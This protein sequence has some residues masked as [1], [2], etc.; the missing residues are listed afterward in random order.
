MKFSLSYVFHRFFTKLY[1]KTSPDFFNVFPEFKQIKNCICNSEIGLHTKLYPSYQI[2]NSKIGNFTYISQNSKISFAKI[3]N[4]CS[5]GPNFLCGWGIHPSKSVSTHPMF[6]STRKQNGITL[7]KTDKIEERKPIEIGH[8][9]FIGANVLI[10]DGVKIGTG[11]IIGAGAV[12]VKDIP[13]YAIA[14]GVPAKIIK[15]RFDE[16][17]IRKLLDSQWFL[18]TDLKKLQIVE[19]YLFDVNSFLAEWEKINK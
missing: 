3:G 5:I 6:Y 16:E 11:A 15:Y 1:K 10:L 18:E 14:V 17:T 4:F 8:D 19:K 2:K 7:S 9:V 13:D 12:V